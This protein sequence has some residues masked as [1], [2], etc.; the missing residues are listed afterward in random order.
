MSQNLYVT[1]AE[2]TFRR[3]QLKG[4][5]AETLKNLPRPLEMFQERRKKYDDVVEIARTYR[6][7]EATEQEVY[8]ALERGERVT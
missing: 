5:G 1:T 4:S 7:F 3:V 6:S 2:A 8:H